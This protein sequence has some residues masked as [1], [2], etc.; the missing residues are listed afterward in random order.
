MKRIY[1]WSFLFMIGLIPIQYANADE[2]DYLEQAEDATGEPLLTDISYFEDRKRPRISL[3]AKEEIE[4]GEFDDTDVTTFRTTA[5]GAI[6]FP[7]TK[8]YFAEV[9]TTAGI[10]NTNFGGDG[11]F[12]DTGKSS[13]APWKDLYEFSLR[14]RSRYLIND[15]WSLV[16]A[17]WGGSRWE[18]GAGFD[19]GLRGAGA[20]GF[21]YNV[22]DNFTFVAGV[23]VSSRMVGGG[24]SVKPWG[25]FS[26][27]IDERHNLATS[28]LG[29]KLQSEWS[30]TITTNVYAKYTGRRW[31]LDDRNDG[32]VNEGSLRDLK[33]PVGVGLQWKFL[34]GWQLRGDLGLV[35]YR[36]L[37][38]T[39]DDG[40]AVDTETSNAPG[41]YG[42]LLVRKRF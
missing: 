15:D 29:L 42:S 14:F 34:K 38:T 19:D 6:N 26:W 2:D 28:G 35:A 24:V 3:T 37:K 10:T 4:W 18:K 23:A 11:Q 31:R 1:Y 20:T 12:I 25:Q 33:V 27:Q 36:Q 32:V 5:T 41:V 16:L 17:T 9:S 7:I 39:N 13:G 40:D 21:A 30:E 8:K 22:T